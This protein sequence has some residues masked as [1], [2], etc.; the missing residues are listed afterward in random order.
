MDTADTMNS[1]KKSVL[2]VDDDKFLVDI[3]GM[4][5][6]HAGYQVQTCLSV[7]EALN[8][9][10]KGFPADAIV[11]DL[12]MPENDGFSFLRQI[13]LEHLMPNA[14]LIV[15]SNQ[16]DPAE[17]QRAKELGADCYVVKASKIPA[18]VVSIVGDMIQKG[19]HQ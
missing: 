6:S 7:N 16:S 2:L 4:K 13:A 12:I 15:L 18:E 10:R 9:L 3:Y 14:M 19:K 1:G 11:F 17:E 8:A 5:F